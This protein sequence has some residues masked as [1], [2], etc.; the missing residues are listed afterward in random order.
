ML[1]DR[2]HTPWIVIVALI[3]AAA[4]MLY[5]W[6]AP[7]HPQGPSGSTA[8]GLGIGIAAFVIMLF[9]VGLG[10][11]RLAPHWRLGSAQSWLR[12]H[13]WLGLLVPLLVA[14]HGAFKA[15]GPLTTVLWVL[16]GVVVVSGL[17]GLVLQQFLPSLLLHSVPGETV[18][19]QL[20]RELDSLV[21]LAEG[22][23]NERGRVEVPGVV[24]NYVGKDMTQRAPDWRPGDAGDASGAAGGLTGDDV[25]ELI[26]AAEPVPGSE[27]LRR[28]YLDTVRPYLAG[29]GSAGLARREHAEAMFES[30]R[31]AT[32]AHVHPGIDELE[33]LC[34]RRRQLL[35][36][37]LLMNLLMNWLYVH[38][39]ASWAL[40]VLSIA[41][42]VAALRY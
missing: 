27:P 39:P 20:R 16:T 35:R 5:A 19:Q 17:Y 3:G 25:R 15:G 14:L 22:R 9:L 21:L 8:V 40:V 38:V 32:P 23:V 34:D 10:V 1:I 26:H 4:A 41:H 42:A 2:K 37:R 30:A 11:K 13:I 12:G 28:F 36:Q 7:R 31:T 29:N 33:S 24:L 18:A 6:D